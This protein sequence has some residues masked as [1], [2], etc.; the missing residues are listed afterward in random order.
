MWNALAP[1][2]GL[3]R[4]QQVEQQRAEPG[5]PDRLRDE[6]VARVEA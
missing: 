5:P 2:L 1:A 4:P 3:L 6:A